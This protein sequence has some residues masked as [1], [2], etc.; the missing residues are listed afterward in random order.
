MADSSVSVSGPL[1]VESDSKHRVAFDLMEKIANTE[2][3]QRSRLYWIT[4]YAQCLKAVNS[5]DPKS[6]LQ[7]E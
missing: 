4:L 1:R 3:E 7:E 6:I 2:R 5:H